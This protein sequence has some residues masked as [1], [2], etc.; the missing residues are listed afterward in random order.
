MDSYQA[1]AVKWQE[2]RKFTTY[3]FHISNRRFW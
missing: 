1:E 3:K 2:I